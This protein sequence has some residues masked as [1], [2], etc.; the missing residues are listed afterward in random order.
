MPG[1]PT[2]EQIAEA[3]GITVD[4]VK[5][6]RLAKREAGKRRVPEP[7]EEIL[8]EAILRKESALADL[9]QLEVAEKQGELI[10][11][12]DASRQFALMAQLTR[13]KMGAIPNALCDQLAAYTDPGEVRAFLIREIDLRLVHLA[14]DFSAA[15]RELVDGGEEGDSASEASDGDGMG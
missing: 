2:D 10:P 12:S 6:R 5:R 4:E 8:P 1:R 3:A 9:R 13:Q 14:N 7:S 11:L 15:A